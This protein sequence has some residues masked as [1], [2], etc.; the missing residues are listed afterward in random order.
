MNFNK[1][2]ELKRNSIKNKYYIDN[3]KLVISINK[4]YY[5]NIENIL[6]DFI[7]KI[8]FTYYSYSKNSLNLLK[9]IPY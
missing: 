8:Y 1:L 9:F 6:I 3:N 4:C 7:K 2:S 5:N